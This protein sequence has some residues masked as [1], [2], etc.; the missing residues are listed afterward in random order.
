MTKTPPPPTVT[1]HA[2]VRYLERIHGLDIGAVRREILTGLAGAAV[3]A[4][5]T[6]VIRRGDGAEIVIRGGVVVTVKK[7]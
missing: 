7:S 2:V 6:C 5:K 4:K 1:E 3:K